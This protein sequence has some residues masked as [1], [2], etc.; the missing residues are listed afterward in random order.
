MAEE[1]AEVEI[2]PRKR[3]WWMAFI[4]G[5]NPRLTLVRLVF[6]VVGSLLIFKFA[7]AP[8]RIRGLSMMPTFRNDTIHFINKLAY[9]RGEPQRG[10][11]ISIRLAGDKVLY[12]KRI[13]GLPGE[14]VRQVKGRIFIDGELIEEPWIQR[15]AFTPRRITSDEVLLG[16]D[17]FFATGDNREISD[18]GPVHRS[19][20]VGR[21]LF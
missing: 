8:I 12:L 13:V 18:L 3:P 7:V 9:R 1:A 6:W 5:R 15:E 4:V 2:K 20:I 21:L 10:D 14:R 17:W 11:V 16:P 19:R